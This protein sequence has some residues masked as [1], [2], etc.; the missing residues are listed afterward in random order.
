MNFR[1]IKKVSIP[2][3]GEFN[4]RRASALLQSRVQAIIADSAI[5]EDERARRMRLEV[6]AAVVVDENGDRIYAAEE[7][8]DWDAVLIDA[9]VVSALDLNRVDTSIHEEIKN[10][11]PGPSAS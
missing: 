7:I 1:K 10:S 3:Y 11:S 9:L 4:L 5:S 8:A 2:D 6:V